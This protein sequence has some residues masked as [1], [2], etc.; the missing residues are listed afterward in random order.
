MAILTD[1]QFLLAGVATV[2]AVGGLVWVAKRGA[3]AAVDTAGGILTGE[4]S[5][6][7]GTPYEGTGLLGSMG[8]AANEISGGVL[9]GLG[10]GVGIWLYDVFHDE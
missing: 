7:K 2:V 8:A 9:E 4:N 1:K 5:L 6:T 10:G 3:S